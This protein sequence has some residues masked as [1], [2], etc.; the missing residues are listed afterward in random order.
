MDEII[1]E[2]NSLIIKEEDGGYSSLCLDLDVA[3]Q[4]DTV[5]EAKNMLIEAVEG[6]IEVSVDMKLPFTRPVPDNA[7]PLIIEP[8]NIVERFNIHYQAV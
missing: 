2:F 1:L 5:E 4:G 3:S 8:E 7:N 6:Y